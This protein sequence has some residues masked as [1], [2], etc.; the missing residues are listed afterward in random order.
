MKGAYILV[1]RL[2]K[3]DE[4]TVGRLGRMLFRRGYYAYVG[5]AMNGIE[6]RVSRHLKKEK[7]LHWHIDYLLKK[8][9]VVHVFAAEGGKNLECMTAEDLAARLESVKG[10]GCSDCRCESHLFYS[11]SSGMLLKIIKQFSHAAFKAQRETR[12]R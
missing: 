10:F 3:S 7:N 2:D 12:L 1:I 9:K 8:A 4:I 11:E 6:Q 5:S